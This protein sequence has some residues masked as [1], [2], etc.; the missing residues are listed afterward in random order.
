MNQEFTF[1]KEIVLSD[2]AEISLK[3]DVFNIIVKQSEDNNF[4]LILSFSCK[5]DS[6]EIIQSDFPGDFETN[7]DNSKLSYRIDID[8]L[9]EIVKT[10]NFMKN[11]ME[12][13]V[14]INVKL[15]I[16]TVH[17]FVDIEKVIA[18][19]KVKTIN[20]SIKMTNSG[21]GT[22]YSTN[23]AVN[24]DNISDNFDI[25]CVNGNVLINH[26]IGGRLNVINENGSI[27]LYDT[28][29]NKIIC[30]SN[31]GDIR[32]ELSS[33]STEFIEIS[34]VNGD[35]NFNLN[36]NECKNV[37][38]NSANGDI[39]ISLPKNFLV[40]LDLQSA[41]GDIKNS[42]D[43][44]QAFE[45][46]VDENRFYVNYGDDL[47]NIKAITTHGDVKVKEDDKAF[48]RVIE[49]ELKKAEELI[50]N[51]SGS[52][53]AEHIK[54]VFDEV[55]ESLNQSVT[56]LKN[57]VSGEDA[58]NYHDKINSVLEQIKSH[59]NKENIDD[60]LIRTKEKMNDLMEKLSKTFSNFSGKPF[61]VYKHSDDK[62]S[63]WN[64]VFSEK[65]PDNSQAIMKILDLVEKE[66]ITAEEAE[67][68]IRSLKK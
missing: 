66:R 19:L 46:I 1:E 47:P 2:F 5:N 4:K 10:D 39:N 29:Y 51:L 34:S 22:V 11:V 53:T 18:E 62:H 63:K 59:I 68:L 3:T 6:S 12:V 9:S 64:K 56:K 8:E 13:F 38:L 37:L 30:K 35:V 40:N 14:P 61:S 28:D 55:F 42:I 32:F 24:L 60:V 49:K 31:N 33:G 16:E 50:R 54:D 23:G 44:E 25:H 57:S 45:V 20:G 67:R 58:K 7:D 43:T 21:H 17:S 27:K 36:D 52:E 41:H 15:D 26:G 48:Y 65:T